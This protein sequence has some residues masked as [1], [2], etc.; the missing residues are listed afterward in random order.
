MGRFDDEYNSG[1]QMNR[2]RDLVLSINEFC[3][4][5]NKTDGTIRAQ[6]GPTTV[7]ISGQESLV[8]F[9]SKSKQFIETND[10]ERAK[11]LFISQ[12]SLSSAIMTTL[13]PTILTDL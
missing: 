12:P 3:F 11:Q 4:V 1:N 6:V 13:T 7:T 2:T 10:I 8:T 9:N 5:Q